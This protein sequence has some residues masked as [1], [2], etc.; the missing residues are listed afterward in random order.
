MRDY[1]VKILGEYRFELR[2]KAPRS[3]DP[4]APEAYRFSQ[5]P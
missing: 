2:Q 5:L 4:N 3:T 1:C